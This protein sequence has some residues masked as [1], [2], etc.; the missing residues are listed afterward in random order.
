MMRITTRTTRMMTQ[1][2]ETAALWFA[3]AEAVQ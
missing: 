3:A 1:G 2:G